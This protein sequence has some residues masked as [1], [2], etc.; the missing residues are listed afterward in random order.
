[1]PE[2]SAFVIGNEGEGCPPEVIEMC[3][4]MIYIHQRGSVRSLNVACASA[5]IM[6][7]YN[8]RYFN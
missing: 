8:R 3:D 1:M 2:K 4:E 5:V 6:A 7:E